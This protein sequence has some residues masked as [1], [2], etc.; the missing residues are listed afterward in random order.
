MKWLMCLSIPLV[1]YSAIPV[2]ADDYP[3]QRYVQDASERYGVEEPL[4][5]AAFY[6]PT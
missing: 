6:P 1:L 4:I 5:R 2:F 3:Y